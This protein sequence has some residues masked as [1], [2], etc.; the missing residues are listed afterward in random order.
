[1]SEVNKLKTAK[2]IFILSILTAIFWCLGQF[3]DVYYFAVVGAI[4]E[5]LWLP[6]IAMLFVLPIFSLVLWAKEKFNPKSLHLYSFLILLA[7]GLFLMLRN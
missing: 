3:V 5:I 4:F 7:T 6:M 1:M 2:I